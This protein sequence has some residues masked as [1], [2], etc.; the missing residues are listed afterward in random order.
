MTCCRQRPHVGRYGMARPTGF[1]C[2]GHLVSLHLHGGPLA[3]SLPVPQHP[4]DAGDSMAMAHRPCPVSA[5]RAALQERD[6][7][8]HGPAVFRFTGA[9]V[10]T[11]AGRGGVAAED[12]AGVGE[13]Q[14][15]RNKPRA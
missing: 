12:A 10:D 7:V 5:G 14:G 3:D 8:R 1:A 6:E 9:D 2:V 4:V 11:H 15:V 13:E